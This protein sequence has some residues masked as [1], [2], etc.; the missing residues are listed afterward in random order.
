MSRKPKDAPVEKSVSFDDDV[1]PFEDVIA[2]GSTKPEAALLP[3]SAKIEVRQDTPA[4]DPEPQ[5]AA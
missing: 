4:A 2:K 1:K 5:E 3:R